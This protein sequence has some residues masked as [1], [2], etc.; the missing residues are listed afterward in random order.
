VG[1][2]SVIVKKP[3]PDELDVTIILMEYYRDEA[4][5]P[6]GEY[7]AQEMA[8]TV[9]NYMINGDYCWYNLY[10]NNR[11]VGL[12]GGYLA[13]IPWSKNLIAHIQFLYTL[14]SHR[15]VT[16]AKML[17]DEFELWARNNECVRLSAGDIGINP[18]RTK[19]FYQQV[20]FND[21]GCWLSK[22][23]GE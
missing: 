4:N 11:P 17:T 23:L 19:A 20:G 14:P 9:R 18:E 1:K 3:R 15:N 8:N 5:L 12:V 10:D 22:E 7:D 6:D 2:K 16:N 13:Q 21:T